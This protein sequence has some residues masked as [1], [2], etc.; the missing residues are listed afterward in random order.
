MEVGMAL[1]LRAVD[2]RELARLRTISDHLA[3]EAHD[4]AI[5]T[6]LA[7]IDPE[8]PS[9][10]DAAALQMVRDRLRS[11][12]EFHR[13][14]PF[15]VMPNTATSG[16]LT[17][18]VQ[19]ANSA[20]V[21]RALEHIAQHLG[22][23]GATGF[24][25]TTMLA[26][27][28]PQLLNAG[29]HLIVVDRKDDTRALAARDD[30]FLILHPEVA[31][32][33]IQQPNEVSRAE[34]ISTI[35]TCFARAFFGGEHLKQVLTDA[36]QQAFAQHA[37]PS[38]ADVL[39]ILQ[40]MS[41]KGDTFTRR[42]A[43]SG[44]SLRLQRFAALYPGLFQ[45]RAGLTLDDLFTHSLY[46]PITTANEASE[47]T[48]T[49]LIHEL[50][51][52]QRRHQRRGGLAY[53]LVL[54][55]GLSAWTAHAS[56]IDRQPLLSY[57]QSMVR[58]YGIG[59]IVT[60]T[61]VQ[62]LDPLL[63]AN[64]GTQIVM[65]LTSAA[66]SSEI[67][68]TFGLTTEEHEFLNTRLVR[69]ECIIKLA[70]DWR[71]PILAT[72]P[73]STSDKSVSTSEWQAALERTNRLAQ[74]RALAAREEI[75]STAQPTP[76]PAS[77]LSSSP[78]ARLA[79]VVEQATSPN[80]TSTLSLN[81]R[82]RKILTYIAQRGLLLVTELLAELHL[83]AMQESRTRKNLRALGLIEEQRIIVRSGR[84]GTAIALTLTAKAHEVLRLPRAH[85]GKGGAQHR[86]VLRELRDRLGGAD[87]RQRTTRAPRAR[88]RRC[89]EH[90]RHDCHRSR[91]E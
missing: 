17:L 62:L 84:G 80:E 36:L 87:V 81:E 5:A 71:H 14:Y 52:H 28:L 10:G 34:H 89:A 11:Y 45:T 19:R 41:A 56:N 46:L 7:A 77:A 86:Y 21:R 78:P 31:L 24:G 37:Q 29:V 59:M 22:I 67:A 79:P 61:S 20:P 18:A 44:V 4:P 35:V 40:R 47:F 12:L 66:E 88:T 48:I 15:R 83:H 6:T 25:K 16:A 23:F 58:E 76:A 63:K 64:L 27:L 39:T 1:L 49:F 60:S 73:R 91:S 50:L 75:A 51:F 85:L 90:W 72:F 3:L 42:D 69:G 43:I 32:N 2:P 65:N 33:I 53:V 82:E 68:R 13:E 9:P 8:Y 74:R 26:R 70:D 38:L 54:D 30:R 57:V 55:E